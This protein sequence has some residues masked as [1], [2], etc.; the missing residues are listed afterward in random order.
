MKLKKI[1]YEE[2]P[3]EIAQDV[4]DEVDY[5][6]HAMEQAIS[7]YSMLSGDLYEEHIADLRVA[8]DGLISI[9]HLRLAFDSQ[10]AQQLAA[11]LG[12][13]GEVASES[14]RTTMENVG[15]AEALV[16]QLEGLVAEDKQ[17]KLRIHNK[18][19]A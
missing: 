14:L 15:A 10:E 12:E 18:R 7:D 8:I 19:G 5:N 2:G 17:F 1:G 16:K 6:Y 13:M 3:E 9:G 4:M 11:K